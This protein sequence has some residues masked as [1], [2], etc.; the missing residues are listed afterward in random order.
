MYIYIYIERERDVYVHVCVWLV[1]NCVRL[2]LGSIRIAFLPNTLPNWKWQAVKH[3]LD[4]HV[5]AE[6]ETSHV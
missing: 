4:D 5:G 6:L 2:Q 1:S 3:N